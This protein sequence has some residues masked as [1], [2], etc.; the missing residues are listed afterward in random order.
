[1][2]GPAPELVAALA[3]HRLGN[4][5]AARKALAESTKEFDGTGDPVRERQDWLYHVLRREAM[6]LID[7]SQQ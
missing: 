7:A 4:E 2:L 3:H 1:V 5:Q 6:A